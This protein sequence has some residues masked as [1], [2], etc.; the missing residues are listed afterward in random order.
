MN[1][2]IDISAM[3]NDLKAAGTGQP[4]SNG[5]DIAAMENDLKSAA[6]TPSLDT[7]TML[8]DLG[9]T[10]LLDG[11]TT[12]DASGFKS[13]DK[14]WNNF[15][16]QATTIAKQNNFPASVLVGQATLETGRG[17]S[18]FAKNRNNYFGMNAMDSDPNKAYAYRSPTESIQ[19]YINLITKSPR[20]NWAY[21]NYLIDHNPN[22]LIEG[23][24]ASGYATDPNYVAK[25]KSTPE[26]KYFADQGN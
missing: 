4:V 6:A 22:K 12:S 25:V 2:Q 7:S 26:F 16:D 18:G 15:V 23:I 14:N 1:N 10:G 11:N 9:Q 21:N 5:F 19:N 13:N 24:R 17:T 20:Y 8:R 3:E